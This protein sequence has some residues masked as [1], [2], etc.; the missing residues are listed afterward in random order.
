MHL[1]RPGIDTE[2]SDP[3]V[4]TQWPVL[5]LMTVFCT[6]CTEFYVKFIVVNIKENVVLLYLGML[7][8]LD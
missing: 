5:I 4:T 1:Y 7:I 2:D 6:V 8:Y 3:A